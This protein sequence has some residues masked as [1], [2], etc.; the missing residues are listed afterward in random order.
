MC[1]YG[2]ESEYSNVHRGLHYLSNLATDNFESVRNKIKNFL[3]ANNDNERIDYQS[4]YTVDRI[5][6]SEIIEGGQS[7]TL[8]IE[9]Q[10]QN[11]SQNLNILEFEIAQIIRDKKNL[12]LPS[13]NG[14]NQTRSD[15][16]GNIEINPSKFFDIGYE[17]SIDNNLE[18][19]NFNLLKTSLKTNNFVTSFEFLEE[20]NEIGNN[21]YLSN[22]TTFNFNENNNLTFKTSENLDKN[23]TEYYNLIYEYKNDCLAAAIEYDKQYYSDES[24]KPE[25]NIL[26]SIK[27]IPFGNIKTPSITK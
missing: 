12:D 19:T 18:T 11:K 21:S 9:Y 24:L 20:N 26:F 4:I 16:I 27:I 2:Y 25:E 17:F 6:Y 1:R 8:G 23:I 14:L 7:L 13:I 15:I 5:G 10:K 3:G 22:K